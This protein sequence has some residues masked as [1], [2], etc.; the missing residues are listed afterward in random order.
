VVV[1]SLRMKVSLCWISGC[2]MRVK[3][4]FIGMSFQG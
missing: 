3:S 1:V 2:V 4:G